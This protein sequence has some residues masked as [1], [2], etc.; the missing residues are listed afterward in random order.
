MIYS[1]EKHF[2]RY[3]VMKIFPRMFLKKYIYSRFVKRIQN[4]PPASRQFIKSS[5]NKSGGPLG[6]WINIWPCECPRKRDVCLQSEIGRSFCGQAQLFN[7]P[8]LAGPRIAPKLF[9]GESIERKIVR[10]MHGNQ[11][12]LQMEIGRTH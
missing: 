4:R 6:P 1:L 3:P 9:G 2:E 12:A 10:R 11:M 5:F 7:G 8:G